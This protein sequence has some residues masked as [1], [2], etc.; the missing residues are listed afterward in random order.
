M[1]GGEERTVHGGGE[2]RMGAWRRGGEDDAWRRG[3]GDGCTEEG[4]R[5]WECTY[6]M[7]YR[8]QSKDDSVLFTSL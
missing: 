7:S 5:G 8:E 6:M 4:R 1:R 3:G 2:E